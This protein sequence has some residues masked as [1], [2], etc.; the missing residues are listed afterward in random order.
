M[1]NIQK[2]IIK[3]I[4][5]LSTAVFLSLGLSYKSSNDHANLTKT[6][7][8][9]N[10]LVSQKN[11][12]SRNQPPINS[13][14]LSKSKPLITN[15][16]KG[17][18]NIELNQ[19]IDLTL[20]EVNR[21]FKNKLKS[22]NNSYPQSQKETDDQAITYLLTKITNKSSVWY[23]IVFDRLKNILNYNFQNQYFQHKISSIDTK[24]FP[25]KKYLSANNSLI[26]Y[27]NQL[28]FDPIVLNTLRDDE[29]KQSVTNFLNSWKNYLTDKNWALLYNRF[30]VDWY[31]LLFKKSNRF[32][33]AWYDLIPKKLIPHKEYNAVFTNQHYQ[34]LIDAITSNKAN[35]NII[36]RAGLSKEQNNVENK[37]NAKLETDKKFL[38]DKIANKQNQIFTDH[39]P[40]KV[41]K[42]IAELSN[43]DPK[44]FDFKSKWNLNFSDL[45]DISFNNNIFDNLKNDVKLVEFKVI[46]DDSSYYP[47]ISPKLNWTLQLN[48]AFISNQSD[49]N[50]QNTVE[51][52]AYQIFQLLFETISKQPN[53]YLELKEGAIDRFIKNQKFDNYDFKLINDLG[54][55][56][57]KRNLFLKIKEIETGSNINQYQ[58]TLIGYY[59]FNEHAYRSDFRHEEKNSFKHF[60]YHLDFDLEQSLLNQAPHLKPKII[61][62]NF[63]AE[64][65]STLQKDDLKYDNPNSIFNYQPISIISKN[66]NSLDPKLEITTLITLNHPLTT[67]KSLTYVTSFDLNDFSKDL[68]NFDQ[69]ALF[70]TKEIIAKEKLDDDLSASNLNNIYQKALA[71]TKSDPEFN[72]RSINQN[73]KIFSEN[74]H[75]LIKQSHKLTPESIKSYQDYQQLKNRLEKQL[76]KAGINLKSKFAQGLFNQINQTQEESLTN[77]NATLKPE[78]LDLID[79]INRSENNLNTFKALTSLIEKYS[80]EEI[81]LA[82]NQTQKNLS[83]AFTGI[84]SLIVISSIGMIVRGMK[85]NS[86]KYQLRK[87]MIIT[88]GAI[89]LIVSVSGLSYLLTILL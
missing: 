88:I 44:D 66:Q 76:I 28:N 81:N 24:Y 72:N 31:Y 22:N 65:I 62:N 8:I 12:H 14:N 39:T 61:N 83:Y 26:S 38:E 87:S 71:K 36:N 85:L 79:F 75:D 53:A 7:F 89:L 29:I 74:Y 67:N 18:S 30:G 19:K 68:S 23:P 21:I 69:L 42:F 86:R 6:S 34:N 63:Q 57:N 45:N 49:F 40:D 48:N 47:D 33:F 46:G 56:L 9:Q 58:I 1:K 82:L 78:F 17:Y 4:S 41:A 37:L 35:S 60:T 64:A 80:P 10:A 20:K 51:E 73:L 77:P 15:K 54:S 59:N 52:S 84:S 55:F 27:F 3:W 11:N 16:I 70:L 25:Y 50:Y 13:S 32:G 5:F 43:R 2:H